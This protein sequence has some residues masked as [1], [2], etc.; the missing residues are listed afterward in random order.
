MQYTVEM[1]SGGM[2]YMPSIKTI[3]SGIRV[4]V[5]SQFERLLLCW[6]CQRERFMKYAIEMA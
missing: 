1:A 3:G 6:Y 2:I 5:L 4:S